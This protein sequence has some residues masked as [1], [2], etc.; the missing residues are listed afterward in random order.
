MFQQDNGLSLPQQ[1]VIITCPSVQ[2]RSFASYLAETLSVPVHLQ[3]IAKPLAQ[4]LTDGSVVLFDLAVSNKKL[5]G[6]WCD[7]LQ[8]QTDDLRLIIFNSAQQHALFEMAR[9]PTLCGVFSC[10]E[11]QERILDGIKAIL[12]GE[13]SELLST[14]QSYTEERDGAHME[15]IPLTERE[16]EILNELRYGASNV[17]IARALFISENTVRTHLYNIF[18]K[19]NVKNRTQAVSWTNASLRDQPVRAVTGVY[20]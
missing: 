17:D 20:N 7:I 10:E 1:M 12:K 4:R 9:W 18:R 13:S 2:S 6:I 15:N 5:N 16:Y 14:L 19:L 11:S 3:N 8:T